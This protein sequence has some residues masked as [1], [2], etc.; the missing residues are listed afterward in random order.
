MLPH[1]RFRGVL[2]VCL[3]IGWGSLLVG[4]AVGQDLPPAPTPTLAP[5]EDGP[6]I[7]DTQP[8]EAAPADTL[9]PTDP[10]V[11]PADPA[12]SVP[13]RPRSS[14]PRM[15][16]YGR[17]AS[18]SSR[19]SVFRL[20]SVPNMFGDFLNQGGQVSMTGAVDALADMPLAGGGHRAKIAENNKA[21]PVD[22]FFFTY[23]HFHNALSA[24]P[25]TRLSG[26]TRDFSV[27]RYTVGLEKTFF[28][29]R[30]SVDV[31]MPFANEY[32]YAPGKFAVGGGDIGNLSIALKRLLVAGEQGALSAGLLIDT[33]TGSDATCRAVTTKVTMHN[34]AVHLSPFV[35][36]MGTP[37]ACF[38]YHGFLQVDV[39]ANGNRVNY[40]DTYLVD[41]GSFGKLSEQTLMHL[42]F[43]V[44]RW[45]YR[46]SCRRGVTGLASIVELHYTT[47]LQ[48][49]DLVTGTVDTTNFTFGNLRNRFDIVNLTVGLHA[50]LARRTTVRV[51][52]VFPLNTVDRPFDSEVQVSVNRRF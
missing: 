37:N 34:D 16:R 33:P 11:Q 17:P 30:W 42:D 13:R 19:G 27:E 31:R 3:A 25:N 21:V 1:T 41:A 50:E 40:D 7:A 4:A 32:G 51:A 45:L 2:M 22:R 6:A 20:A 12:T 44:G 18:S 26:L 38:F 52:G 43:S 48:D 46:N 23:H 47:A 49:A 39:A 8:A 5:S 28:D 35:A 24:N 10:T 29:G 14:M 15:G 36:A 9:A